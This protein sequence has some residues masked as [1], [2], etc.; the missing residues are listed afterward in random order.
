MRTPSHLSDG[1]LVVKGRVVQAQFQIRVLQ[2]LT[3]EW[4]RG[5]CLGSEASTGS[6]ETCCSS[7]AGHGA[8]LCDGVA[9]HVEPHA[10][11]GAGQED[12]EDHQGA[13]QEVEEGVEDGAEK[14]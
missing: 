12:G 5:R 8:A 9:P 4:D 13:D 10:D 6:C 3:A 1:K 2:V 7:P 11:D 14:R